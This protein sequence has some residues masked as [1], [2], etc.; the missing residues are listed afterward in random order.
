MSKLV[1]TDLFNITNLFRY[2]MRTESRQ[3]LYVTKLL[4]SWRYVT[5]TYVSEKIKQY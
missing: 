3:R 5:R 1:T 2:N 4:K